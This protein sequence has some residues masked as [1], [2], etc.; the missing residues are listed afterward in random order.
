VLLLGCHRRLLWQQ[1]RQQRQQWLLQGSRHQ[2]LPEALK[3]LLL[4]LALRDD[5]RCC[6][7]GWRFAAQGCHSRC[8]LQQKSQEKLQRRLQQLLLQAWCRCCCE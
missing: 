4:S 3:P 7:A 1:Y 8:L 2:I 5:L 6:L